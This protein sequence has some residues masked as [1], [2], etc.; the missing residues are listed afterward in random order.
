MATGTSCF[1]FQHTSASATVLSFANA[2]NAEVL[3]RPHSTPTTTAPRLASIVPCAIASS[4][5]G[6]LS[7][8]VEPTPRL[9]DRL[10]N[11]LTLHGEASQERWA[12]SEYL[13]RVSDECG[14][15]AEDYERRALMFRRIGEMAV[16]SKLKGDRVLEEMERLQANVLARD[17]G[18]SASNYLLRAE[19]FSKSAEIFSHTFTDEEAPV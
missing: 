5:N 15:T 9:A 13:R 6:P 14:C 4:T 11:I 1:R 19:L 12:A 8:P 18:R 10:C 2:K 7:V 17:E 16:S 3:W